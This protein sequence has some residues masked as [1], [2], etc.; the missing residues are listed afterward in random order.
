METSKNQSTRLFRAMARALFLA[1]F[2]LP[3]SAWG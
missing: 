3:F 2:A 1:V